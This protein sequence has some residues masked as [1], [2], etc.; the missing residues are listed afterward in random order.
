ML[1]V[2]AA[3]GRPGRRKTFWS[4]GRGMGMYE[5]MGSVVTGVRTTPRRLKVVILLLA[6]I[7]ALG[8][9][10]L[11]ESSDGLVGEHLT[12]FPA[13]DRSSLAPAQ[14]KVVDAAEAEFADPGEGPD[15]SEGNDEPW[16]ANFVSW[17]LR[18]AGMPLVNP[19]SGSW[20]IPGVYT[21]QE[22]Y[23]NLGRFATAG[24]GYRPRT[25]D[26]ILYS[27]ESRFGQHTNIVLVADNSGTLTTIGG[28]EDDGVRIERWDPAAVPDIH[29]VGYGRL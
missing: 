28:N 26:V 9:C 18:A 2:P 11:F 4:K 5:S 13:I 6:G 25:G 3:V 21:L 10:S 20:R 7:L 19:N 29:I 15:Y 14:A 16:C 12:T 1:V 17:V 8:G 22:H 23:E 27:P 24:S